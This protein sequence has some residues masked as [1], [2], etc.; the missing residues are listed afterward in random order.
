MEGERE[1]KRS[2]LL[3]EQGQSIKPTAVLTPGK[4]QRANQ[5]TYGATDGHQRLPNSIDRPS[6]LRLIATRQTQRITKYTRL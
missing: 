4:E 6:R 5:G 1:R 2:L 3:E